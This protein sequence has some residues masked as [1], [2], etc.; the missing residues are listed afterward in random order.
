M[1]AEPCPDRYGASLFSIFRG[2][3]GLVPLNPQTILLYAISKKV[4]IASHLANVDTV[5]C[6]ECGYWELRTVL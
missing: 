4:L 2:L 6:I 1:T 5:S 3:T